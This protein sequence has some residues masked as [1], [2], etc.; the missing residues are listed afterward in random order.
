MSLITIF[1]ILGIYLSSSP[2][3]GNELLSRGK[4]SK[5][6]LW[7]RYCFQGKVKSLILESRLISLKEIFLICVAVLIK[8]ASEAW[9]PPK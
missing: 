3:Y 5:A 1:L 9:P 7:R 8:K 4:L 6:V 2:R